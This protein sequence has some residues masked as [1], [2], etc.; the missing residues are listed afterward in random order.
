MIDVAYICPL[1][2]M[3]NHFDL[4]LN[5]LQ[6]KINNEVIGDLIF[7]FSNKEHKNKFNE[8]MKK[9]YVQEELK[10]VILPQEFEKYKSKAV[11]KKL[12]GLQR[13][14]YEYT[15]IILVDCESIFI[16][17]FDS[18][19]LCKMIWDSRSMLASNIS[20]D[21]FNI[22]RSCY[23][24]MGLYHNKKLRKEL[25]NFKYNF[26]FNELQVYKSSYLPEFFQWLQKF[27]MNSIL[28]NH[29]CFEYYLFFAHLCIVHNFHIKKYKY[30]S[31]G[32]INEYLDIF[33]V[34]MQKKIVD[35]MGLHWTSS[36]DAIT[37]NVVMLFHLDR[38]K[39]DKNYGY[40]NM[41]G[42]TLKYLLCRKI[43]IIKEY[44]ND[45]KPGFTG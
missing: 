4:A 5:L 36:Q 15:Y 31:M 6:S 9:N 45:N 16:K 8:M 19:K 33:P 29:N 38:G 21:G 11:T 41:W 35:V 10:C 43:I 40:K 32:G 22:M 17:N 42:K 30:V 39:Y 25:S 18:G 20:P 14:M 37:E 28:N 7:I 27:N 34:N 12:Y 24:T 26:W 2:D 44:L 23:R 13:F 1:Y 3:K